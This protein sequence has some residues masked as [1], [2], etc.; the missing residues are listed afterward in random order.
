MG[1]LR[2]LRSCGK[3]RAMLTVAGMDFYRGENV[4]QHLDTHEGEKAEGRLGSA[5]SSGEQKM[6]LGG[7]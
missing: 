6:L 3:I 1:V 5:Q 7:I 4:M 2:C